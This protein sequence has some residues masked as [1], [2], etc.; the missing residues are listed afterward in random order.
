MKFLSDENIDVPAVKALKEL[1][2]DIISVQELDK[3]G[4]PDEEI[5]NFC[6]ENERA[7]VTGDSDYLRL[8]A[9]GAEHA[10][11]VYLTKSLDTS[12]LIREIQKISLMFESIEN[13]IVFIPMK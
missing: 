5:L 3:R 11:I 4:S 8:H 12:Q 2:V 1:G 13:G 9:K 10:G 7:V 6:K